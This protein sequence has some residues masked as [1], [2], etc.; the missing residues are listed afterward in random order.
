MNITEVQARVAHIDTLHTAYRDNEATHTAV[1]ELYL[2]VIRA[3]ANGTC[4][5]PQACCA[6]AVEAEA[7]AFVRWVA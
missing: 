6:A 1:D 5:D 7:V 2:D 3:I 4:D